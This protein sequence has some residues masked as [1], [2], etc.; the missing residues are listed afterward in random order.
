MINTVLVCLG[1][2]DLGVDQHLFASDRWISA[3][4]PSLAKDKSYPLAGFPLGFLGPAFEWW[5]HLCPRL[6]FP[7]Q[8][9]AEQV[10]TSTIQGAKF[11]DAWQ[12]S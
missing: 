8:P 4:S 11:G 6:L 2:A 3:C 10:V 9:V 5:H 7:P 12:K 1:G